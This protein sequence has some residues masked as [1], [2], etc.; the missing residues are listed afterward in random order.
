MSRIFK[1]KNPEGLY[2]VSFAVTKWLPIFKNPNYAQMAL[3]S[4]RYCQLHKGMEILSWC[5]MPNHMHFVYRAIQN[6]PPGILLGDF[7]RFTSRKI[8]GDLLKKPEIQPNKRFL[9]QFSIAAA[10]AH[11]VKHHQFWRHD[12]HPI[13]LWSKR[14]IDIKI[15]YIHQN[16]VKAG[17]VEF[18]EDYPYSSAKDYAGRKGLLDDVVVVY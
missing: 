1:F 4:L 13:E 14:I 11:N 7:K 8:V 15:N 17:L 6:Q 3:D 10:G 9:K 2:F 12:N 18:P 5:I 16:P